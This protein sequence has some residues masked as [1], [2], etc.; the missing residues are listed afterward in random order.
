[1]T[2]SVASSLATLLPLLKWLGVGGCAAGLGGVAQRFIADPES[3]PHR[4]WARYCGFLERQLHR[5]FVFRPGSHI[6]AG[7][8][9]GLVATA[10]VASLGKMPPL[11]CLSIALSVAVGPTIVLARRLRQRVAKIDEQVQGFVVA[12]ANALKS[13]PAVGDAMASVLPL[14]PNPLRQE[15]E[16]AVKQMRLGSTVEQSL[17]CMSARIGSKPLDTAVSALLIGRQVGGN[18]PTV[19]ETTAAAM[20][21]MARLQGVV[22]TKTAEGKAQIY[23]LAFFPFVLMLA[24]NAVSPGYFDTFTES[25]AGTMALVFAF[26]CWG[27]SIVVARRILAVDI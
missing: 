24:F 6:A 15:I 9:L 17:L 19:L 25:I 2:A 1:M 10:G 21:E 22:R 27:G 3:L 7:Q 12:V 26:I 16:V 4:L 5:M 11:A 14:T 8:I 13:R 18:L 23:V 20:R